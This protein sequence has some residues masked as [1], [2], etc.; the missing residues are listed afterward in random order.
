MLK[1][2]K[3]KFR[4]FCS[5]TVDDKN[6]ITNKMSKREGG[7]GRDNNK[8]FSIEKLTLYVNFVKSEVNSRR[9]KCR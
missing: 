4:K 2:C 1:Y 8:R 9:R 6:N 5:L 7:T 3:I